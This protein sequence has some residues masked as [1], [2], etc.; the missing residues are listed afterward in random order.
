MS[1]RDKD[2]FEER[3]LIPFGNGSASFYVVLSMS[4]RLLIAMV[5]FPLTTHLREAYVF[6]GHSQMKEWATVTQ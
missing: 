6:P 4:Q 2:R 1:V 3:V 5:S